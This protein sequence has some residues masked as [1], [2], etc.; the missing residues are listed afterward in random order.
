[1]VTITTVVLLV[2]G[3]AA[4]FLGRRL[5]WLFVAIV[6]FGA[7]MVVAPQ[8]LGTQSE[9]ILLISAFA[10]GFIGTM[11]ALVLQEV[12]V[13]I[14]GFAVGSYFAFW[15]LEVLGIYL[16]SAVHDMKWWL[17]FIIGGAIG[18]VLV[19]AIFDYALIFL[20]SSTGATLIVESLKQ[21][22]S[23]SPSVVLFFF[24]VL[25]LVGVVVQTVAFKK[26]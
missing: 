8:F 24:L 16:S 2:A 11:L 15:I 9:L 20:S 7:G 17:I 10:G 18:A 4:L 12:A 5:F 22:L 19:L 14:A 6:G 3:L 25:L 13:A 1:M 23:L 26:G 21:P